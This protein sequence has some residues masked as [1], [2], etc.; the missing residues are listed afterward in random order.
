MAVPGRK[1]AQTATRTREKALQSLCSP[2][3]SIQEQMCFREIGPPAPLPEQT[4][5]EQLQSF[6]WKSIFLLLM[7]FMGPSCSQLENGRCPRSRNNN[8]SLALSIQPTCLLQGLSIPIRSTLLGWGIKDP[9]SCCGR[10]R[11]QSISKQLSPS[12]ARSENLLF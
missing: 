4:G 8:L 3:I 6:A 5:L 11:D 12:Q 10:Q 9:D 1:E 7:D 2:F